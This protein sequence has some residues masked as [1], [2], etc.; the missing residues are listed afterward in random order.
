MT[1]TRTTRIYLSYIGTSSLYMNVTLN[2]G[3]ILL[4][5]S[6]PLRQ[7]KRYK[8]R[9]SPEKRSVTAVQDTPERKEL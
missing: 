8:L 2:Y 7:K 1:G 9:T 5:E 4:K 3:K 6:K